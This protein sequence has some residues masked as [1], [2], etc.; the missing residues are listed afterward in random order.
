MNI[1]HF[2]TFLRVFLIPFFPLI[3]LHPNWFGINL[4]LMPVVLLI[5]LFICELTDIIDGF[6]ARKKNIV[7]NFGKV[8]D[9]M[10]DTI[11]HISVFFT[12]TQGEVAIPLLLVFVLLYR[13]LIVTTLRTLCALKGIAVG[14][15]ISGKVKTVVMGIISFAVVILMIPYFYSA[16]SL[17]VLQKTSI[18]LVVVAAFFSVY[19]AVDY[20]FANYS[21]L[22]KIIR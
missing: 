9:P 10:A 11:T 19:S 20:F 12:F 2:L 14:A 8:I 13:E 21:I 1:A 4:Y 3:Y 15:R 18:I 16:I 7:T 22:K 5:I 17:D 6:L